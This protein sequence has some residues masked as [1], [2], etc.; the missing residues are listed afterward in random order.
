MVIFFLPRA[1]RYVDLLLIRSRTEPSTAVDISLLMVVVLGVTKEKEE[2][3]QQLYRSNGH[4]FVLA[5]ETDRHRQTDRRS[6][7]DRSRLH[8]LLKDPTTLQLPNCLTSCVAPASDHLPTQP[9]FQIE[10]VCRF[11]PG[12][13]ESVQIDDRC[14]IVAVTNSI[15]SRTQKPA[16]F[17]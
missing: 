10:T 7:S 17:A 3:K 1:Q 4:V 11:L 6:E 2:N 14:S 8:S 12:S 5:T 15:W 13:L 16:C 9:C